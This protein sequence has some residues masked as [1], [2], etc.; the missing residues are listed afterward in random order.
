MV[1]P[2]GGFLVSFSCLTAAAQCRQYRVRLSFCG[3]VCAENVRTECLAIAA[4]RSGGCEE[5]VY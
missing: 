2:A 4:K 1:S 3:D 5:G